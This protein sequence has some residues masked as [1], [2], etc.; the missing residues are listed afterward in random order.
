MKTFNYSI[1]LAAIVLVAPMTAIAQQKH[2]E[3]QVAADFTMSEQE[4][5]Q[6]AHDVS[7]AKSAEER[8]EMRAEFARRIE[9]YHT[10]NT[11]FNETQQASLSEEE[12]ASYV[13]TMEQ[14]ENPAA[15]AELT[16]ELEA[17]AQE[18]LQ[19]VEAPKTVSGT[20]FASGSSFGGGSGSDG[21]GSGGGSGSDGGGSGGGSGGGGSDGGGS[22]GR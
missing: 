9:A 21:G 15:R 6:Y 4:R 14:T 2:V 10:L 8:T 3:R 5:A 17:L 19:E 16:R 13:E 20:S 12:V 1:A 11:Q 7:N 22:G 18:N